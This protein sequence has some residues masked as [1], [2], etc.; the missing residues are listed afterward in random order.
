[1]NNFLPNEELTVENDDIH[2]ISVDHEDGQAILEY[3]PTWYDTIDSYE[4]ES[5][6]GDDNDEYMKPTCNDSNPNVGVG[7]A[8]F[9]N[10]NEAHSIEKHIEHVIF[11][12]F[13]DLLK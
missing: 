3:D 12:K 13:L 9:D 7:Y 5:D 1:M 8:S 4:N 11:K 10:H 2:N 6:S